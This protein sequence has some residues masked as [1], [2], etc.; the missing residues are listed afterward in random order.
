MP[1]APVGRRPELR[2]RAPPRFIVALNPRRTVVEHNLVEG[3]RGI[4]IYADPARAPAREITVRF[5]EA[6]NI[7]GRCRDQ[8]SKQ[9]VGA[10]V[11]RTGIAVANFVQLAGIRD[12]GAVD[13][14][15]NYVRNEPG[16]SA[17]EDVISL[18]RVRGREDRP[19]TVANNLLIGAFPGHQPLAGRYSGSGIMID[20]I[21]SEA[22]TGPA[23]IKIF[24]NRILYASNAGIGIAAGHNNEVFGNYVA[25]PALYED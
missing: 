18:F 23:W 20:G 17:V 15:W 25:R 19:V 12:A 10:W 2:D 16:K 9:N 3:T 24:G 7:D 1:G 4:W 8:C 14:S 22:S 6:L 21:D 11:S 13:I 5:N